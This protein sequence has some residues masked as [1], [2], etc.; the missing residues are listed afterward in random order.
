MDKYK[1]R[2]YV[3]EI[4][5]LIDNLGGVD[6]LCRSL[7]TDADRGITMDLEEL[8]MRDEVYGTNKKDPFKRTSKFS[9]TL[10]FPQA[11]VAGPRRPNAQD[12]DCGCYYI[13][14]HRDD[15]L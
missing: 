10:R 4:D 5:Y 9:V 13:H 12:P 1:T 3:E 14:R 11:G 6:G 2:K 8:N 7:K 15:L